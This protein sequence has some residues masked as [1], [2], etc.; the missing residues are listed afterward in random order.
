MMHV[1]LTSSPETTARPSATHRAAQQSE[2]SVEATLRAS[3]GNG[4]A[5]QVRR[6][7]EELGMS[8]D[9]IR[10]R[11]RELG[12]T[13]RTRRRTGSSGAGQ[14]QRREWKLP[15]RI[16]QERQ[17]TIAPE[18]G[19]T[20]DSVRTYLQQIGPGPLL[21]RAQE[22]QLGA[23]AAGGNQEAHAALTL[24]NLRLVVRIAQHAAERLP[25][26][27]LDLLDL[28]Q[29]GNIGLM[30]AVAGFNSARGFRF[31]TY[32]TFWIR[33]AI[34]RAVM[35]QSRPIRLPV[36]V[37]QQI[38]TIEHLRRA[39]PEE[40]ELPLARIA[41]HLQVSLERAQEVLD[42]SALVTHSLD[43][44]SYG[45]DRDLG[46][47]HALEAQVPS[48]EAEVEARDLRRHLLSLIQVLTPRERTILTLRY[49]LDGAGE[50]TLEECSQ[51]LGLSRESIR[52]IESRAM[53]KLRALAEQ[54][55]LRAYLQA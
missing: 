22:Q 30:R 34:S 35:E 54:R 20:T 52:Q 3:Y 36:G 33:Q 9:A 24:A 53:P 47:E 39:L 37:Q 13:S 5:A 21:N 50:R 44:Q 4:N 23:Q 12:L 2:A 29:E 27:A 40:A 11:A 16:S 38:S 46:L 19:A 32:A 15:A 1:L 48:P 55:Q 31:S 45:P 6:L 10:R 25:P 17:V 49:G 28:I 18:A 26:C 7:S 8:Q 51:Q 14:A 41:E 42:A 43:A